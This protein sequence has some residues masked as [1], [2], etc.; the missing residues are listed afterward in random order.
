MNKRFEKYSS[1]ELKA[2]LQN[3]SQKEALICYIYPEVEKKIEHILYDRHKYLATEFLWE[4]YAIL[5]IKVENGEFKGESETPLNTFISYWVGIA[6]NKYLNYLKKKE[7]QVTNIDISEMENHFK[8]D[9]IQ[10]KIEDSE[11]VNFILNQLGEKCRTIIEAFELE[12]MSYKEILEN[13]D[14]LAKTGQKTLSSLTDLKKRCMAKLKEMFLAH[15][16]IEN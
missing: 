2:A 9:K 3:F 14:L 12:G 1:E 7:A 15:L 8:G 11:W 4:A 16:N 10:E 13:S 6:K 5:I